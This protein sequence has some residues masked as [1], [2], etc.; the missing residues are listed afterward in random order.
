LLI[1]LGLLLWATAVRGP[2][3]VDDCNYVSSVIALRHGGVTM[4]GT[5]GLTPSCELLPYDPQVAQRVV[6]QTPVAP[7]VPPLYAPFGVLVSPLGWW[8]FVLLNVVSLLLLA[9]LLFSWTRQCAESRHA[10]WVAVATLVFGGFSLEYAQAAWPHMLTAL[11]TTTAVWLASRASREGRLVLAGAAGLAAGVAAGMR[12]QNVVFGAALG[13]TLLLWAKRRWRSAAFFGAGMAL[14]LALSG[15]INS[16]RLGSWNPV[17]KGSRYLA[18]SA[19]DEG[20]NVVADV[21]L[22]FWSRV[23]D[24]SAHPPFSSPLSRMNLPK[25][26]QTGVFFVVG[27]LKKALLQSAPWM[28]LA[29]LCLALACSQRTR[30]AA[31][32]RAQLRVVALLVAAVVALFAGAGLARHDGWSFNQRYLFELVPLLALALALAVDRWKPRWDAAVIGVALGLALAAVPLSLEPERAL[33]QLLMMR[34]PLALAL[35]LVAAWWGA[36]RRE[37]L[38]PLRWGLLGACLSWSLAVHVGDDMHWSRHRRSWQRDQLEALAA[39]L[40]AGPAALFAGTGLAASTCSLQLDR[41]LVVVTPHVGPCHHAARLV[42]ELAGQGRRVFVAGALPQ[43]FLAELRG[44]RRIRVLAKQ[45]MPIGELVA[46]DSV[47]PTASPG[48]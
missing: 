38:R 21:L 23:V 48:F 31:A 29:L 45:P 26:E 41:D 18:S 3:T 43:R 6:S 30:L 24:Y 16:V 20:M 25:S 10:P 5:A 44:V 32:A 4:P 9:W 11:M 7:S 28:A 39:A 19:G 8:G 35:L 47:P 22:T 42:E 1:A 2:F 15:A 34:V 46:V 13:L 14:P 33:R 37:K 36:R 27:G 17:S 40:P 12:Y